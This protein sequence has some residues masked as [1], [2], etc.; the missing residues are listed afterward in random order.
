VVINGYDGG[1]DEFSVI[2]PYHTI[3]LSKTGRYR[4]KSDRLIEAMFL[5]EATFDCTILEIWK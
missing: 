3:P 5:A 4:V 2:D 1:K